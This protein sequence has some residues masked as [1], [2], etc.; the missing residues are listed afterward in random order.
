MGLRL[1]PFNIKCGFFDLFKGIFNCIKTMKIWHAE[2]QIHDIYRKKKLENNF[3]NAVLNDLKNEIGLQLF[4]TK[5]A[6]LKLD[7][8]MFP[9]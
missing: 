9:Y 4:I 6:E 2:H 1:E 7:V 8:R 3:Q 5:P